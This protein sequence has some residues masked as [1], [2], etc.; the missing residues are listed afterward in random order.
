MKRSSSFAP[1]AFLAAAAVALSACVAPAPECPAPLASAP[2]APAAVQPAPAALQPA[3]AGADA[4]APGAAPREPPAPLASAPPAPADAPPAAAGEGGAP[5]GP[6]VEID[7]PYKLGRLAAPRGQ[8]E[9]AERDRWNAGG[10]GDP[11]AP[12]PPAEGH[13]LPRIIVDVVKVK[14]PLKAREV[15]RLARRHLWIHVYSCYRLRA[16]KDPSLHGKTTVRLTVSRTGKVTAA[17]ATASTL[18]APDVASCLAQRAKSLSLPRARAG[19]AVVVTMQ[20]YPGDE[21]V[22]PPPSVLAPGPGELEPDAIAAAAAEA[23]PAWRACYEAALASAPAL[24]GRLAIRFH[25]TERGAVDE[26]FEVESRFPD[27]RMTRCVL[28]RARALTFPA[29]EGGDLRFVVPLRFSPDAHGL[30]P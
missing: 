20:V 15:E 16:Y 19:S 21:P 8:A 17:R 24:W 29:P 7:R 23:L 10:R 4:Q 30:E 14:G 2:P 13:P 27:E 25:V 28:R 18:S 6:V 12:P 1:R 3:P 22:E 26:A 11:P 9:A 5:R